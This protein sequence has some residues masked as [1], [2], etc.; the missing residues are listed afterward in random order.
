MIGS[1]AQFYAKAA[2]Q[3]LGANAEL[4]GARTSASSKKPR[5]LASG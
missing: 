3:K 2:H 4:T 1:L 5:R